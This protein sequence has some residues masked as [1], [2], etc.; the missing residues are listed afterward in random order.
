MTKKTNTK[1]KEQN[2]PTVNPITE[3]F[4]L[5]KLREEHKTKSA[6]IRFLTKE[7]YERKHIAKFMNIRY[8]HVRN[9]QT[10]VLKK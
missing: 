7:G 2:T 4:D 3:K 8:Q 6:V 10:Q 9:V 5:D 1:T